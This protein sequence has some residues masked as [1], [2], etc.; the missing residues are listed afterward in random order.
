MATLHIPNKPAP[1]KAAADTP[2]LDDAAA[3]QKTVKNLDNKFGWQPIAT[4]PQDPDARFWV[5]VCVNGKPV[6]GTDTLVKYR[7]SRKRSE[8][9]W[10]P[11]LVIVDD[12]LSTKLGFK[13]SEWKAEDTKS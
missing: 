13:P 9:K 7:V 4:A 5:R 3:A 12:K 10:V 2:H 6:S 1:F 8:R 11:A